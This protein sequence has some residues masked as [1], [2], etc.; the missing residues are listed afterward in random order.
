MKKFKKKLLTS[1]VIT[2]LIISF[3]P[4]NSFASGSLSIETYTSKQLGVTF[5]RIVE[6]DKVIVNI[7]SPDGVIIHT[8]MDYAEKIYLDGNVI[9]TNDHNNFNKLNIDVLKA[10]LTSNDDINWGSWRLNTITTIETGGYSTAIIAGLIALYAGWCPLGAIAAIASI[11]AGMYDELEIKVMIRYG[12]DDEYEYYQ[13]YT[14]FYGDGTLISIPEN[15][16]YDSG[17]K[18]LDI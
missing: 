12:T 11:T 5:E 17:K 2:I 3:I 8:L 13:R 16:V 1:L 9:S 18:F 10:D 15:P 6:E 7:K 14:Y 4:I